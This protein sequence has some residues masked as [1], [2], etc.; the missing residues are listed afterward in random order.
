MRAILFEDVGTVAFGDYPEPKVIDPGDAVVRVTTSA[1]CGSDLHVLE[2]RLPGVRPGSVLGHEYVGEVVAAGDGVH[3]FETGDRVVGSFPIICGDCWY[4]RRSESTN[5]EDLRILG[6]GMFVGDL[7]GA[8]AEYV[9]IP[10]AD[11]NLHA[12]DPT[13]SDEQAIF[14]GDIMSTGAYIVERSRI[15]SGDT[16]AIVGA[17]PVGLFAT[18]FALTFEPASVYVV[19][20]EASRLK[21]AE[22]LGA[23]PIDASKANPV[24]TIQRATGD[25]GA[26]VVIECVGFAKTFQTALDAVRPGGTVGV[27]GVHTDLE[28]AFPLGEVWRRNV[29]IVMGGSA[30]VQGTWT[31]ALDAVRE[32][33]IDPTVI[34]SHTMPIEEG[35]KGY[36]MFRRHEA[37]KVIL[38]P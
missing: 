11:W 5:C 33:S 13:L 22:S 32:G 9:R 27:I 6:Y 31:R 14:A 17:G 35:V 34:I 36:E 19:D 23:V 2:G 18:M 25:R 1:I 3:R 21:I 16:V 12:I 38:K 26:D 4:C 15:R 37:L 29:T 10:K 28:V 24:T 7:D 30:N 20:L 8:Q